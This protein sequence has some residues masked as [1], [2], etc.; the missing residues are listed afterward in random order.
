MAYAAADL[1][2]GRS[3]SGTLAEIA[4]AGLPSILVPFPGAA[5][6]HQEA[7]ARAFAVAGA[8]EV[9]DESALNGDVLARV[10][11]EMLAPARNARMARAAASLARPGAAEAI[12]DA[13][14]Q[15]GKKE[16]HRGGM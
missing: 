12:A 14:E 15:A 3:G 1:F 2:L 4:C 6:G 5:G 16:L 10:I 11:A 8:A 9:C 7:N 13:V